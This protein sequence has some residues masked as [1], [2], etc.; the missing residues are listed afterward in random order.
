MSHPDFEECGSPETRLIEECSELI[1]VVCKAQ[2]FG[3]QDGHPDAY[4]CR[5]KPK[6]DW[7]DFD[8]SVKKVHKGG[9]M[10]HT[11]GK[12]RTNADDLMAEMNDVFKSYTELLNSI[13]APH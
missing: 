1:K 2:R 5:Q 8:G 12:P 9:F 6:K 7:C 11:C 3:W 4:P 10:G 13:Y